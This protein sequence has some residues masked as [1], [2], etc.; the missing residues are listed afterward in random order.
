MLSSF[1]FVKLLCLLEK[2]V[3]DAMS[4]FWPIWPQNL[5]LKFNRYFDGGSRKIQAL[6]W[7]IARKSPSIISSS[8]IKC[9]KLVFVYHVTNS[10]V[11][12]KKRFKFLSWFLTIKSKSYTFFSLERVILFKILFTQK[13]KSI[14]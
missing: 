13:K 3:K 14:F 5:D 10:Y 8:E 11:F 4:D 1:V 6:I 2:S 7:A 12:Y 9:S